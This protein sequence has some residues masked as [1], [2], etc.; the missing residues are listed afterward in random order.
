[1]AD[2]TILGGVGNDV[3]A[4]ADPE[5]LSGMLKWMSTTPYDL[6]DAVTADERVHERMRCANCGVST[7]AAKRCARC[8]AV[9][10]C[11]VECQQANWTQHKV[12]CRRS[13]P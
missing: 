9:S 7:L 11:S 13:V 4:V 6:I 2:T 1:M 10:Y 12:S 8:M 5:E 3:R